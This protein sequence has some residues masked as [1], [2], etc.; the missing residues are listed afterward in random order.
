METKRQLDSINDLLREIVRKFP[1]GSEKVPADF[2]RNVIEMLEHIT[3]R[4]PGSERLID[5]ERLHDLYMRSRRG[6]KAEELHSELS[7]ILRRLDVADIPT[8][9]D[10]AIG[11]LERQLRDLRM[12]VTAPTDIDRKFRDLQAQME[13]L[14][15]DKEEGRSTLTDK[16][17]D[18]LQK[19]L[20]AEK[21]AFI[22][23]PFQRDFD[24]VW[25]GAIKPA[26]TESKFAPLRV[27]E[28]NLSSLITD[29]IERYSN[30]AQVVIVDLTGN[31]P[32]V[33]FELGW[34]LAKNKRPIVLCQGDHSSKVAF[35]VRGIRHISYE[36]SWLGIEA[37]K[38]KL[39]DFIAT[40]ERQSTVKKPKEAKN[41][42]MSK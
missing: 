27:D 8:P 23:M 6:I 7:R 42:K 16:Q 24:N 14:R 33:M 36:N 13:E 41:S 35:D 38:K 5:R 32:N 4:S 37:L 25:L 34:S 11:R 26:C 20:S 18:M 15:E 3:M 2:V 19:F 17:E 40:T 12:M 21:K 28:V 39:K 10:S 9:P 30:M 22:I 31:N 1:K 29:D